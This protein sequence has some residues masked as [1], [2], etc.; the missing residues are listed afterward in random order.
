[1]V[2]D[3]SWPETKNDRAAIY[4][5]PE[6]QTLK[7]EKQ[8]SY[9]TL[10]SRLEHEYHYSAIKSLVKSGRLEVQT[11][12]SVAGISKQRTAEV[13]KPAAGCYLFC[14]AEVAR[15]IAAPVNKRGGGRGAIGTRVRGKF[16][17]EAN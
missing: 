11:R 10:R 13:S 8:V 1:M 3:P 14:S 12:S 9:Q 5:K 17:N 4:P 6:T 16:G 7:Y 2:M 15:N